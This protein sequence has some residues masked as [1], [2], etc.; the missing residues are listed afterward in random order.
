[1][2][3]FVFV[4]LRTCLGNQT[5]DFAD[6]LLEPVSEAS[7]WRARTHTH[8][9]THSHTHTYTHTDPLSPVVHVHQ[10]LQTQDCLLGAHPLGQVGAFRLSR[11]VLKPGLSEF[12]SLRALES[13]VTGVAHDALAVQVSRRSG[14]AHLPRREALLALQIDVQVIQEEPGERVRVEAAVELLG[15]GGEMLG[16]GGTGGHLGRGEESISSLRNDPAATAI[17]PPA[18][19]R[20]AGRLPV[21]VTQAAPV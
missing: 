4:M 3:F 9:H 17:Q 7:E 12:A 2:L 1:M 8:T 14:E 20:S 18:R 16:S 10:V 6:N 21:P 5:L 19:R 15:E 11:S 13:H